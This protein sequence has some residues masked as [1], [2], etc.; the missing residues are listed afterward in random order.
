MN[1]LIKQTIKSGIIRGFIV[2]VLLMMWNFYKTNHFVWTD[3]IINFILFTFL[4]AVFM[5]F[6]LKRNQEN[7]SL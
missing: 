7:N 4:N 2:V 6:T 1:P 3:F 5:Y